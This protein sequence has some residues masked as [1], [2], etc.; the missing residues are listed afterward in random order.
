MQWL[1][2]KWKEREREREGREAGNMPN[3]R[4]SRLLQ[5]FIELSRPAASASASHF[6]YGTLGYLD[7]GI[8]RV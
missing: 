5:N 7:A 8:S 6:S 2:E 3:E 4:D 1:V